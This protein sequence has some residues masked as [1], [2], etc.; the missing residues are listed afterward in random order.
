M[1]S[2]TTMFVAPDDWNNIP[3]EEYF[4]VKNKLAKK[5]ISDFERKTGIVLTPYIEEISVASP[6][7]FARYLGVPEGSVYG[8]MT[9]GWD[10]IL[11]RTVSQGA[12]FPIKGLK[13][14]GTS[15]LRGDGYSSAYMCGSIIAKSAIKELNAGGANN[16]K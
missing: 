15:G 7:T 5:I 11:S 16:G 2:F 12:D 3:D 10:S 13:P 6:L 14:I 4:K 1:C 8:Y 9:A